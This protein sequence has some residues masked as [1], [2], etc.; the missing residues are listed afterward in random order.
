MYAIIA[1]GGKQHRIAEGDVTRIEKI[2]CKEGDEV[3][4]DK[5]LLT[6]DEKNAPLVG[7]P[8]IKGQHVTATVLAHGRADKVH[9]IKFKRRK[10]YKRHIGHRQS[11]TE[12]RITGLTQAADAGASH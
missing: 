2:D 10:N 4:F 3:S 11:Y 5:V 7:Q 1:E 12:V 9:V 6:G 8:Y